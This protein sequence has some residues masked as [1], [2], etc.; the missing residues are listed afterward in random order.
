MFEDVWQLQNNSSPWQLD[1]VNPRHL[2]F[3]IWEPSYSSEHFIPFFLLRNQSQTFPYHVM[4]MTLLPCVIIT[5]VWYFLL[6]ISWYVDISKYINILNLLHF[7]CK[8]SEKGETFHSITC[9]LGSWLLVRSFANGD[10]RSWGWATNAT[11]KKNLG[12]TWYSHI[13]LRSYRGV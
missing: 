3:I 8:K 2:L 12:F 10:L 11:K 5:I 1:P 7:Q 13:Y 6:P 9:C 4:Q